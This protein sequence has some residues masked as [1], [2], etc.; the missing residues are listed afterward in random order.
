VRVRGRYGT[1]WASG[2]SGVSKMAGAS[3]RGD[4]EADPGQ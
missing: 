2:V 1:V 4:V 3:G